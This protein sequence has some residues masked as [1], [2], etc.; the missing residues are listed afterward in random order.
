M[1]IEWGKVREYAIATAATRPVYLDNAAAPIPPTFLATVVYWD[2]IG[3]SLRA[4][5]VASACTA[6]GV[7]AERR[8][9]LSLEQEYIF[10]GSVPRAGET[11]H[12]S[13]RFQDVR[14]EQTRGG[15]MVVVRFVVSFHD[16]GGVLRAEC[17]YTS[18]YLRKERSRWT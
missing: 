4:P 1:P 13:E 8:N 12:T 5:E 15:P 16:D 9:L 10:H 11:L 7:A 17:R 14:V 18:A 6:V 2:H 3:T